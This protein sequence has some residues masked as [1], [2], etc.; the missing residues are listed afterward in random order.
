MAPPT[1]PLYAPVALV[2]GD[3]ATWDDPA[4]SHAQ[5]G[6]FSS[7]D[8]WALTY[9]FVGRTAQFEVVAATEGGGWRTTL[10]AADTRKLKDTA[11]GPEPEPVRWYAQVSKASDFITALSGIVLVQPDPAQLAT[12]YQ[13]HAQT[14]VALIR[15]A[16]KDLVVGGLK[17]AQVQG[18]AYTKND[19]GELRL[20][21]AYYA[22][23]YR[24]EI[25]GGGLRHMAVTFRPTDPTSALGTYQ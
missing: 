7:T 9:R 22:D 21:L 10:V 20:L 17:S 6:S 2:A 1:I 24:A 23:Q 11:D 4:L 25:S 12:G 5:Y 16:I 19:L 18:R 3:S 15:T 14:M 8:G 13:S